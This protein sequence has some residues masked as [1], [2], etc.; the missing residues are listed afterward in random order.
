V[1]IR[2]TIL[3]RLKSKQEGIDDLHNTDI[4]CTFDRSPQGRINHWLARLKP[5]SLEKI[6][7]SKC[8]GYIF[9]RRLQK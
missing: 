8:Q 3:F 9:N 6:R 7:P 1:V 2:L 5:Q 4:D